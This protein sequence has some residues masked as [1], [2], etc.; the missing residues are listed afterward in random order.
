MNFKKINNYIIHLGLN[1]K[2]D[3]IQH[4]NTNEAIDL[5]NEIIAEYFGGATISENKGFWDNAGNPVYENSLT[6]E[7]AFTEDEN[8][9]KFCKRLITIFNQN[10]VMVEKKCCDLAMIY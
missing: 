9:E 10:S 8:I 5:V 3:N 7:I 1:D 4:I 6:I 2:D